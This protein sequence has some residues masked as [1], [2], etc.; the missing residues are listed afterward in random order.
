VRELA[1]QVPLGLQRHPT[2]DLGDDE[3]ATFALR[4]PG[5]AD[6]DGQL[7]LGLLNETRFSNNVDGTPPQFAREDTV[8]ETTPQIRL[9]LGDAPGPRG[10]ASLD[11]EYYLQLEYLPTVRTLIGD[12]D[13]RVLQRVRADLGRVNP[14]STLALHFEYDENLFALSG[15]DSPEDSFTLL[16]VAP[17]LEYRPSERTLIRALPTY[18][19]I[20]VQNGVTDR[21]DYILDL[22]LFWDYSVKTQLGAGVELRHILFDEAALGEVD[23]EYSYLSC[24]WRATPKLFVQFRAGAEFRQLDR[25]GDSGD[26]VEPAAT[27]LINWLPAEATSLSAGFQA[28][29]QPSV[30]GHGELYQDLRFALDGT[31]DLSHDFYVRG[32]FVVRQRDYETGRREFECT[33]RPAIGYRPLSQKVLNS[34]RVELFYQHRLLDSNQPN[35]DFTQEMVGIQS[36]IAF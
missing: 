30:T 28:R 22:G 21:S 2:R 14:V 33:V 27:L 31:R 6:L 24:T 20:E 11:S 16:E 3:T 35:A 17:R 15:L 12:G 10:P 1:A 13:E 23:Y 5:G 4:A 18:D 8:N 32:E 7:A 19:R 9:R 29:N 36:L 26:N 34:L 25:P